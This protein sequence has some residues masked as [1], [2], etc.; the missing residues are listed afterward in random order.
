MSA[1]PL[2]AP[3]PT[4][5][6]AAPQPRVRVPILGASLLSSATRCVPAPWARLPALNAQ[7][8]VIC[9][10]VLLA[11]EEL[12]VRGRPKR[13]ASPVPVGREEAPPTNT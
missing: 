7:A 6:A 11:G 3:A 13:W 12:A 5:C 4:T 8:S 9:V 10:G 1:V 2:T